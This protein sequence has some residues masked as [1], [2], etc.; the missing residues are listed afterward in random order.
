MHLPKRSSWKRPGRAAG[1]P[2]P[3]PALAV[4]L[5]MMGFLGVGAGGALRPRPV[6]PHRTKPN[7][8]SRRPSLA[9][10]LAASRRLSKALPASSRMRQLLSPGRSRA[11]G[12]G[13]APPRGHMGKAVLAHVRWGRK[14]GRLRGRR[15]RVYPIAP[16]PPG[17]RASSPPR[18]V[19]WGSGK[20]GGLRVLEP[21][22]S[23][24]SST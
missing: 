1:S 14:G 11:S 19:C 9:I 3:A 21:A 7:T 20:C 10:A 5:P 8:L 18:G 15:G 4:S 2:A 23:A 22:L 13:G 6:A 24:V 12:G 17:P 16:R